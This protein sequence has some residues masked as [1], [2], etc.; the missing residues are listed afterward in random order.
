MMGPSESLGFMIL[1]RSV[2]VQ[3]FMTIVV[4]KVQFGLSTAITTD[5]QLARPQFNYI[6]DLNKYVWCNRQVSVCDWFFS[7]VD[8]KRNLKY[9]LS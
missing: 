9:H 3:S 4:E 7:C 5:M 6:S 8:N 1:K 2:S